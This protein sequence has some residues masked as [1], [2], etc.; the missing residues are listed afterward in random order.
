MTFY[1]V[2]CNKAFKELGKELGIRVAPTFIFY[3]GGEE[4]ATIQGA[5]IDK[6]RETIA[7][8]S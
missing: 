5:K 4:V 1:K 6:I 8:L 7:E 2:N 3:K